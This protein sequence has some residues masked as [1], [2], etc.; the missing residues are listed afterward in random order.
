MGVRKCPSHCTV[1]SIAKYKECVCLFHLETQ[2]IEV[3]CEPNARDF[4]LNINSYFF[5]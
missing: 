1:Q 3:G 5:P 4:L 2:V